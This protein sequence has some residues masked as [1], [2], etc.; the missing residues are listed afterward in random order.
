MKL[1]FATDL[2][3]L[4]SHL[5][6]LAQYVRAY[7]PHVLLIGGDA[8]READF[9]DP[10][11]SQARFV[12]TEMRQFFDDIRTQHPVTNIGIGF[13]N[14]DWL[15]SYDAMTDLAQMGLVQII[16]ADNP[17]RLAGHAFLGYSHAPP[18][19]YPVKDFERLD[20]PGQPYLFD[21]GLIWD[22]QRG[23]PVSVDAAVHLGQERSIREDLAQLPPS[24]D[25]DWIF[26][27]HAPP[28]QSD[29]DI[30][31][32]IGHVGSASVKEFILERQPL[33]SLHG[34]IHESPRLSGRF[35][36]RLGRTIAIN[37]GQRDDS[38]AAV[39][40][41]LS[42]EAITLTPLG[43]EGASGRAAV[44]LSRSPIGGQP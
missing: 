10:A 6:E 43:I 25:P 11:G 9:E 12:L 44:T 2:H 27:A 34:H 1:L 40:V 41:D 36:Q 28:A 33:L 32:G 35:W 4:P 23:Q 39:L 13:G 16:K 29:L 37:P 26:V 3:G 5:Q 22:R 19:P 38:L 17:L 14:H 18:S 31:T 42:D 30:L 7:Q 20:Q 24:E 8:L 15:C 21:G